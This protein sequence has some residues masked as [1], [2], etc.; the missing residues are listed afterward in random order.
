MEKKQVVPIIRILSGKVTDRDGIN[1]ISNSIDLIYDLKERY[2][3]I[4]IVD[5]DGTKRNKPQLKLVQKLG[6]EINIWLDGG[7]RHTENVVD[8]LIAG[9]LKVVIDL[10]NFSLNELKRTCSLT[11]N[12]A[13]FVDYENVVKNK[14]KHAELMDLIPSMEGIGI[15]ILIFP[16]ACREE[17]L[18]LPNQ[19][20]KMFIRD[21]VKNVKGIDEI[22]IEEVLVEV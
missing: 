13:L 22:G 1:L 18:S 9:A 7:V 12:I 5:V 3:N 16:K 6:D 2:D 4:Y 15:D 8:Y 19:N 21:S 14:T 10:Q 11:D 17:I 20:M